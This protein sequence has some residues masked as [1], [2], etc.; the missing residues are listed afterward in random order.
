MLR[1]RKHHKR[2]QRWRLVKVTFRDQVRLITVAAVIQ[3]EPVGNGRDRIK[4]QTRARLQTE[5]LLRLWCLSE[6]PWSWENSRLVFHAAFCCSSSGIISTSS[7]L[8]F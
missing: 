7:S 1:H 4:A 8:T 2:H 3:R 5:S 6:D